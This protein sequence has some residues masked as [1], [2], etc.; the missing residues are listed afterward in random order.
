MER[1][2]RN[3]TRGPGCPFAVLAK[4]SLDKTTWS[5]VHRPDTECAKHKQPPGHHPSAHPVHLQL[6]FFGKATIS[7]LGSERIAPKDIQTYLRQRDSSSL[8]TRQDIYNY[9]AKLKDDARRSELNPR[10]DQST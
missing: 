2:R 5:V 3:T 10:S 8:A 9:I 4:E 6:D 1:K 7:E